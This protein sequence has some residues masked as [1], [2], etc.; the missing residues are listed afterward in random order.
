METPQKRTI[1]YANQE[2]T[3]MTAKGFTGEIK[4]AP[5]WT[6]LTDKVRFRIWEFEGVSPDEKDGALI[7]ISPGG[8]T[9]VQLVESN[10]T[11]FEVPQK[12]KL[13][14]LFVDP[15]GNFSVYRFNSLRDKDN[16]FM[17]RVPKNCFMSWYA[18]KENQEPCEVIEYEEPG[19]NKSKL[20]DVGLGTESVNGHLVPKE[21]W[22]VICQLEG[23]E[24]NL[25][26]SILDLNELP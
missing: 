20:T 14:F 4:A 13:L 19:F 25:S 6:Q 7:E 23:G 12:G 24:E 18:L 5:E 15:E 2:K 26:V 8:R 17:F 22:E 11:F 16:S 3:E 21:L 10:T 9:P 1:E